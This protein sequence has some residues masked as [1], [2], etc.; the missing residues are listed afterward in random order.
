MPQHLRA[1]AQGSAHLAC[2]ANSADNRVVPDLFSQTVLIAEQDVAKGMRF[3][4][5][6]GRACCAQCAPTRGDGMC[7]TGMLCAACRPAPRASPGE[8]GECCTWNGPP[9]SGGVGVDCT[10][11]H[12]HAQVAAIAAM[13]CNPGC[14][15]QDDMVLA[16]QRRDQ[17]TPRQGCGA[18]PGPM[19]S[20]A[21]AAAQAGARLR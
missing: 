16:V 19:A 15:L 20:A 18:P 17:A 21:A 7:I 14:A 5:D 12:S 4:R 10:P 2:L 6:G 9:R 11:P 8:P 3:R 13:L 1:Q